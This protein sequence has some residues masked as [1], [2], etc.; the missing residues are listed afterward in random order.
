ML[1][2]LLLLNFFTW[3]LSVIM[4]KFFLDLHRKVKWD[5]VM[6]LISNFFLFRAAVCRRGDCTTDGPTAT[7][8]LHLWWWMP[9]KFNPYQFGFCEFVDL[10]SSFLGLVVPFGSGFICT[11]CL[12][13]QFLFTDSVLW[14]IF[15]LFMLIAQQNVWSHLFMLLPITYILQCKNIFISAAISEKVRNKV[16][17]CFLKHWILVSATVL[18][19]LRG[20]LF[21]FKYAS[22]VSCWLQTSVSNRA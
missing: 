19:W 7:Q 4:V 5:N 18:R 9:D 21:N 10:T 11:V 20:S 2:F 15:R 17:F 8:T 22:N 13:I 14:S 12:F 1:H 6:L 3:I 16:S